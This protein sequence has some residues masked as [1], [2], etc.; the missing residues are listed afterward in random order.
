MSVLTDF[1][2]NGYISMY[3]AYEYSIIYTIKKSTIFAYLLFIF[4]KS[5]FVQHPQIYNEWPSIEN[6]IEELKFITLN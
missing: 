1:N 3:E 4:H 6:N 2:S 5:F